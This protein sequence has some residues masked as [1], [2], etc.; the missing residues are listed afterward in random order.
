M[1]KTF[2]AGGN[3]AKFVRKFSPVKLSG[4]N[5]NHII[6]EVLFTILAMCCYWRLRPLPGDG[7]HPLGGWFG[8]GVE[9]AL[10]WSWGT[11]LVGSC[12]SEHE[13]WDGVLVEV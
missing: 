8:V 7:L 11:Q 1:D 13:R 10:Q 9:L 4:Y 12:Y 6:L 3:T 5:L 2:A